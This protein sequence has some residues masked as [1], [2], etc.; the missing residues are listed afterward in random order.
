MA[1]DLFSFHQADYAIVG[2]SFGAEGDGGQMRRHNVIIAGNSAPAVDTAGA[3]V[4]G[5]DSTKI[6][7]LEMAMRHGYGLNDAESLW[8]RGNEISEAKVEF[9]KPRPT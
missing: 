5:F 8:T 1:V 2:G 7:H 3:A 9:R 6:R 4:M